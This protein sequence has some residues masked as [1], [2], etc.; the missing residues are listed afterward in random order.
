MPVAGDDPPPA[1]SM[2]STHQKLLHRLATNFLCITGTLDAQSAS[3]SSVMHAAAGRL[4]QQVGLLA[5]AVQLFPLPLQEMR[6]YNSGVNNV[7]VWYASC[8][9]QG[10]DPE[11]PWLQYEWGVTLLALGPS[12]NLKEA[13]TH[14]E[15]SAAIFAKAAQDMLAQ[16]QGSSQSSQPGG[17]KALTEL[18][19][20]TSLIPLT[21]LHAA[22]RPL[23]AFHEAAAGSTD[24]GV[25]AQ[26]CEML[27]RLCHLHLQA[28]MLL[29]QQRQPGTGGGSD[30]ANG[31]ALQGATEAA[32]QCMAAISKRPACKA[33]AAN[34]RKMV[35]IK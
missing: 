18:D 27:Q 14:L 10:A 34:L 8:R 32:R 21:A 24:S 2:P 11:D 6:I 7:A 28:V 16:Q 22:T 15:V 26:L 35:R 12:S 19:G 13:G 25:V 1:A 17:S 23:T 4:V 29:Q 31:R 9:V 30:E 33:H 5:R 3:P 20:K